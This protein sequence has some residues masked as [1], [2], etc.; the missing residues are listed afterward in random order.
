MPTRIDCRL[1]RN[2]T[3]FDVVEGHAYRCV[4]EESWTDWWTECNAASYSDSK[5]FFVVDR[6][7]A[8]IDWGYF[9]SVVEH[10][11][12]AGLVISSSDRER[13]PWHAARQIEAWCEPRE[14]SPGLLH[15]Q[16]IASAMARS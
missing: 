13:C 11:C 10:G 16:Q 9:A 5:D 12:A 15:C 7:K 6:V 8:A 2:D 3:K 14:M 1:K 4:T